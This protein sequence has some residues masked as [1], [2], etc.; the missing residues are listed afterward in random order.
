[1][2]K[3]TT[4]K[5][6]SELQIVIIVFVGAAIIVGLFFT[7]IYVFYIHDWCPSPEENVPISPGCVLRYPEKY[8]DKYVQVAGT[9]RPPYY[10]KTVHDTITNTD[11]TIQGT[12]YGASTD[13]GS[14]PVSLAFTIVNGTNLSNL[15]AHKMYYWYGIVRITRE[16]DKYTGTLAITELFLE[17][18]KIEKVDV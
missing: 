6:P 5:L 9:Y 17:V 2:K 13:F 18:S 1:M 15:I 14:V 4:K 12:I 10:N 3:I 7:F 16:E 11:L 8:A